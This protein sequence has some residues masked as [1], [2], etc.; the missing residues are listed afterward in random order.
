MVADGDVLEDVSVDELREELPEH[1]P[2]YVIYSFKLEHSDGRVSF[3][4][5]FIFLTPRDCKTETMFMYAGSK[6]ALVKEAEIAKVYELRELEEFTD[7]W[8]EEKLKK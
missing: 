7:E 3:P 2:R 1:L 6:L 8:L 4:L 5:C